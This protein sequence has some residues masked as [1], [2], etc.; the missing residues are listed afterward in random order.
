MAVLN[1][2][3]IHSY[4]LMYGNGECGSLTASSASGPRK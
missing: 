1:Q 4:T 2:F 3:K